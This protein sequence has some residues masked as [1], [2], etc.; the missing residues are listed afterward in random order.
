MVVARPEASADIDIRAEVGSALGIAPDSL[1]LDGDL[2]TQGLDSL[3]MMRL[4]GQWRKRGHDIDFARLSGEPTIRAWAA[5]LGVGE[6]SEHT[7]AADAAPQAQVADLTSDLDVPFPLAP[8]QHAYWIG[9]SDSHAYGGVAAHLYI[10][11]DGGDLEPERFR[12]AVTKL[13][14]RH[15]MLRVRVLPD[16]TQ[17]VGAPHPEAVAIHDLREQSAESAADIL[18]RRREQGT[19]RALPIEDGAVVRVELSLLPDGAS[20]VHLDVDM[21]A[22]DAMSYRVLVD[23]LARLYRGEELPELR[24]HFPALS[25]Q[26][27]G[28]APSEADIAWWRERIADLPGP[29]E[30]PVSEAAARG[31]V[32]PASVR[33]HHAI[34]AA[35]RKRLEEYAHRRGVTPASA[36]ATVFAEAVGAYSAGPRFLL[37]VPL[38]DRDPVHPDVEKVVGDFTSSLVV[39]VDLRENLT[40]AERAKAMRVAMH[41]AAAH[42]S[43][44]GLDVLRELSRQR[45]EPVVSP[46]VFTSALGLGELFSP[47]V[48]EVLGEPSWIVSQGPQVLLDA[49]VTEVAGGLLLNWDVRASDLELDT[50]REMF[51]YYV[52]LLDLLTADDWDRPAP[53]PV[54]DEVRAQRLSVERPLPA[55]EVFDGTLH[56]HF[57][58]AAEQRADAPAIIGDARTWTHAE[59]AQEARRIAGALLAAGVGAGDTVIVDLPKGGDQVVAAL[60]V[61][62]AGAAYVPMAPTQPQARRER[63]ASVATPAA[64]LTDRTQ[65]WADSAHTVL[66]LAAARTAEPAEPVAVSTDALAY[67]LFTSGSTGLPKG[68][69]V[70]HRAAVATLTDLV[71]RYDLGANDRSLQVSSLEF[72]LSV[73]DIFG[74]LA[75]GGAVVVPT[76]D[77]DAKVDTWTRLLH[78]AQ[79]SVL[80]CVPSILGMI[81]DIAP[82]PSTLRVIIMGGDKVDVSLLHRVGAQLPGCRVAGLG[83]TTETAIHSTVCEAPD[84]P[85]GATFV[86][87]GVPLD[88]VRC[89]VVDAVGRDRPDRIPGELWIGGA[90]VADGYRGD[91]ERTADRFVTLDGVRWYRT[92]DMVRYLPGGFLDFLGRADHMVKI[93]GYRVELG[94]VEAGL[95][96]LDAVTGAVAWSDGRDLRAAVTA[97]R[98]ATD[99]SLREQLT[100]ALPPHM[101]PRSITV[102][103]RLPLTS[104]GKYDRAKVQQLVVTEGRSAAVAPR[105]PVESALV[106]ILGTVLSTRPLGVTDD[107]LELGGDSVLATAFV[108]KVRRWLDVPRLTV[109]EIFGRRTL[110]GLARRLAELDGE[111]AERVAQLFLEVM[112]LSDTQVE[113]ELAAPPS[114][115]F[116]HRRMEVELD[117]V[118]AHEWLTHPKSAYWGMLDSTVADVEELIRHSATVGGSPEFGLRMGSY[119]GERSFFFE[120]YNPAVGDL[121]KPGTG[122]TYVPGD[123]GMHLLVSPSDKRLPGFTANVML[124]IMR[125]AFFEFGAQRVVVEPDVRNLDVQ[126]LNAAVGFVVAGDY[127]VADKIARLSYCT[128]EDFLRATDN[129]R[130]VTLPAQSNS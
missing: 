99:E 26:R 61:L 107:F 95:L 81:L 53:D 110:E 39:D 31:E 35:D 49:Q 102:V 77:A 17:L 16:G 127:P 67:V 78:D 93:R 109:A 11:F 22:A 68:V 111:R 66:E 45:G 85:A 6:A 36:V 32:P 54:S 116:E 121:A 58:A 88:G 43:F 30:L 1:D 70:P 3:R 126:R 94:E 96:G 56:G 119:Q 118:L 48:T 129:G 33:L 38:F 13:L 7:A 19:H 73:F 40:L 128:R 74:L 46:V 80:N 50:A 29:P 123:L 23:D 28:R 101:I 8:M 24:V 114:Y 87:Y 122:Y 34:D 51:A 14:L 65:R 42:G 55:T 5:L 75:V 108:A 2:I 91:P 106:E 105:D 72:D 44:G 60:G 52:R 82:L 21:I 79:V 20:R 47:T 27:T 98:G 130:T 63:I 15:P 86:P 103:D 18:A 37:T 100:E 71:R 92:G 62:T 69:Q 90:G 41:E 25:A 117:A 57:L 76:D 59:L 113:A 97:T 84:V 112:Q 115:E 83:G 64:I 9:R 124:H 12:A 4:A 104:N 89:R 120:L 10:E 125:T